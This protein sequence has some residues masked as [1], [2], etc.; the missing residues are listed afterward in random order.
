[1]LNPFYKAPS[2]EEIILELGNLEENSL[3]KEQEVLV[4]KALSMVDG[5][6]EFFRDTMAKDLRRYFVAQDDK[7]REMI[8]GAFLR[9]EYMRNGI[10]RSL[11]AE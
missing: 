7:E 9:T 1:M 11:T 6:Q 8:R 4:F 2:M 5:I 3:T 10:K